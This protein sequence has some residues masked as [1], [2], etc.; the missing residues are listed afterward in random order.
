M[1]EPLSSFF[2]RCLRTC[3]CGAGQIADVAAQWF[4]LDSP[5]T[6]SWAQGSCEVEHREIVAQLWRIM[7]QDIW[8]ILEKRGPIIFMAAGIVETTLLNIDKI[9]ASQYPETVHT[10]ATITHWALV[11]DLVMLSSAAQCMFTSPLPQ[12]EIGIQSLWQ[13]VFS[14]QR[15]ASSLAHARKFLTQYRHPVAQLYHQWSS[16]EQLRMLQVCASSS[17]LDEIPLPHPIEWLVFL[18]QNCHYRPWLG[19][20]GWGNSVT[21]DPLPMVD[22]TWPIEWNTN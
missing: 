9:T 4:C 2:V 11:K 18:H 1:A 10:L 21:C 12:I 16:A 8:V 19:V 20:T 6:A 22:K 14:V 7:N 5:P 17:V 15:D 13:G 3:R